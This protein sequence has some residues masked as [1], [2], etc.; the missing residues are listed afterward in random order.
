[1]RRT[2][3][4]LCSLFYIALSTSFARTV[5][6]F[7]WIQF[8][9]GN[10]QLSQASKDSLRFMVKALNDYPGLVILIDGHASHDEGNSTLKAALSLQRAQSCRDYLISQGIDSARLVIKGWSDKRPL[11]G[12]DNKSI[13]KMKTE[14]KEAAYSVNRRVE[15]RT[16][17]FNYTPITN[18]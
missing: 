12:L 17:R 18:K 3:I 1:M 10:A 4:I 2:I 7:P 13:R 11:P 16:L 6:H 14:E 15:F 8:D 5:Q 9:K